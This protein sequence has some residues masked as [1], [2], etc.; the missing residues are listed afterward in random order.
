MLDE[1]RAAYAAEKVVTP[2]HEGDIL[3][4][5]NMLT[6]HGREAF[7][8]PRRIAVGMTEPHPGS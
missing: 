7:T 1:L 5:D 8:L 2:W 3:M 6:A 4:L